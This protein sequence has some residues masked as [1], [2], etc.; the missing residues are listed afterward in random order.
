MHATFPQVTIAFSREDAGAV[1]TLFATTNRFVWIGADAAHDFDAAYIVLHAVTHDTE[2]YP[3]PCLYCQL[4]EDDD[5]AEQEVFFVPTD[6]P[7]CKLEMPGTAMRGS[8][9]LRSQWRQC[10][11][12]FPMWPC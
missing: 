4:D 5:D 6:E 3:R 11:K 10:S 7:T 9:F 1:G 8:D 2:S 12:P